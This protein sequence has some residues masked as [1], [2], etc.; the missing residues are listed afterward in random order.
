M[1]KQAE[2]INEIILNK[3]KDFCKDMFPFVDSVHVFCSK[4]ESNDIGTSQMNYG[5]G[6]YFARY[7]QITQWVQNEGINDSE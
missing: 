6:N 1:E 4:H 2:E 3:V 5:L 7:G